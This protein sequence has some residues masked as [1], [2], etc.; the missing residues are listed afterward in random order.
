[1]LLF[2]HFRLASH[3]VRKRGRAYARHCIRKHII[4][5]WYNAL[6]FGRWN[7]E[8]SKPTEVRLHRLGASKMRK[9]LIKEA[10]QVDVSSCTPEFLPLPRSF[11]HRAMIIPKSGAVPK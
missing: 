3:F 11:T 2:F 9:F 4:L 6:R 8:A 10:Y 5:K 7:R 1:M